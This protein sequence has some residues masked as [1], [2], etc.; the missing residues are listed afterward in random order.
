MK[1]VSGPFQRSVGEGERWCCVI[2]RYLLFSVAES[3]VS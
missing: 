1:E 2:I 3:S